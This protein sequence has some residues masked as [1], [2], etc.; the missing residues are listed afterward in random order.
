MAGNS[1]G[2]NGTSTADRKFMQGLLRIRY[3]ELQIESGTRNN[4]LL[5]PFGF[6]SSLRGR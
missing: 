3:Q 4:H 5:V 2:L 6:R 1:N